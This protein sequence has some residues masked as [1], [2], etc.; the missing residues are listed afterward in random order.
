MA[1][2]IHMPNTFKVGDTVDCRINQK[3]ERVTWRDKNTLVIEPND[4]RRIVHIQQDGELA[5]FCCT[6]ADGTAPSICVDGR[7]VS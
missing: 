2:I 6:D 7:W 5:A 4:A 1:F 3:P